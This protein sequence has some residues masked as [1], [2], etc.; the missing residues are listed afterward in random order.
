MVV[1]LSEDSFIDRNSVNGRELCRIAETARLLGCRVY[2][3]PPNFDTCETADNALAYVPT[4]APEVPGI[5]VG[6]IP[7]FEHYTAIFE[8][9][10]AKGVRL[11]NTPAEFQTALEIALTFFDLPL[12]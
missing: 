3:I 6:Y 2:P 9:A 4:F 8:A 10:L 11:L 5:W 12:T 1:V 7:S